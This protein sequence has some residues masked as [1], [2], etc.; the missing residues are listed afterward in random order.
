MPDCFNCFISSIASS[1]P[2]PT[3]AMGLSQQKKK[4]GSRRRHRHR[5]RLNELNF[6]NLG[7]A[8]IST[9]ANVSLGICGVFNLPTFAQQSS[10]YP[11]FVSPSPVFITVAFSAIFTLQA[12]FALFQMTPVLRAQSLIQDGVKFYYGVA[13]LFQIC[14]TAFYCLDMLWSSLICSFTLIVTLFYLVRSQNKRS[15]NSSWPE[16]WLLKFPF[17]MHLA[18]ITYFSLLNACNIVVAMNASKTDQLVAAGISASTLLVLSLVEMFGDRAFFTVALTYVYA[19]SGVVYEY[20]AMAGGNLRSDFN[21][22]TVYHSMLITVALIALLL[23]LVL[24]RLI[25]YFCR[26]EGNSEEDDEDKELAKS[27][28]YV[29]ADA[30]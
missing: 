19:L 12:L 11:T 8:A 2:S 14:F 17:Q 4:R 21:N 7:Y 25:V 10:R 26:G 28:K 1:A 3:E 5:H 16:F 22:L 27:R 20:Y 18:W 23:L 29:N 15:K 24:I 13:C 9:A 30:V 6:L